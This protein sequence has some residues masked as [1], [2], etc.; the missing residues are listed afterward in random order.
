MAIVGFGGDNSPWYQTKYRVCVDADS[1]VDLGFADWADWDHQ[2]Q[3]VF[4]QGGC[5]FRQYFQKLKSDQTVKIADFNERKF[6]E[7][8]PTFNAQHW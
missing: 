2:G 7:M 1:V 4:A 5:L 8:A 6:E 3:L